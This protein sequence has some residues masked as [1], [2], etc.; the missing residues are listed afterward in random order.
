MKSYNRV[1]QK[2]K[3]YVIQSNE[4]RSINKPL[5]ATFEVQI[6]KSL[7]FKLTI[8]KLWLIDL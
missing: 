5:R 2:Y 7:N 6:Y 1:T 8:Y 3:G 4:L